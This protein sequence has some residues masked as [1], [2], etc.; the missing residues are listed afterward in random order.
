MDISKLDERKAQARAWFERLRDDI[1][2]AFERLEDE[3]PATLYAGAPGRFVR[4]PWQRTDA[5]G[6]PGGGGVMGMMHGRFFEK[7]GVHVSTVHGQFTADF[8]KGMPGANEDPS[9]FATGVSVIAHMRSPRVPAVH[10]NTRYICTTK[11]WFGGGADLTPLLEEQRSQTAD[12][13]VLFHAALQ[14][15]LRL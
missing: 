4:T 8:A 6:N 7:V 13:A 11:G 5:T 2:A 9:F 12:D 14:G 1:C 10:M 3:A 15:A